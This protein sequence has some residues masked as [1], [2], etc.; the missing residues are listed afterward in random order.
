MAI[1]GIGYGNSVLIG[2]AGDTTAVYRQDSQRGDLSAM[3]GIT[4]AVATGDNDTLIGGTVV[5][6]LIA[7]GAAWLGAAAGQHERRQGRRDGGQRETSRSRHACW[8]RAG[9][10][11]FH[12]IPNITEAFRITSA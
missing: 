4:Q 1:N 5:T 7:M 11:R 3:T 8:T 2:V 9:N 10:R 6:T 12:S